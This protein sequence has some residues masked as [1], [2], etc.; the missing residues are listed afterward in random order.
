MV[1]GIWY[2]YDQITVYGKAVI[3]I[4]CPIRKHRRGGY[5]VPREPAPGPLTCA[6]SRGGGGVEVAK[7]SQGH[8]LLNINNIPEYY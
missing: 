4:P 3:S 8:I 1:Y 6:C 7:S 2:L 5:D